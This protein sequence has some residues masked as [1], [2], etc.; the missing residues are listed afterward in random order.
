MFFSPIQSLYLEKTIHS[1]THT[2]FWDYFDQF[3]EI[4]LR[5]ELP[6]HIAQLNQHQLL[7]VTSPSSGSINR[8]KH[9]LQQMIFGTWPSKEYSGKWFF[10]KLLPSRI[11]IY[12]IAYYQKEILSYIVM[13]ELRYVWMTR[14]T[15]ILR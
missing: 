8:N 13:F 6:L 12:H 3:F 10:K 4:I 14:A 9:S 5:I 11:L 1:H 7:N 15:Q 2:S